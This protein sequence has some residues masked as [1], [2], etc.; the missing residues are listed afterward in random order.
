MRTVKVPIRPMTAENFLPYGHL[1]CADE[2]PTDRRVMSLMP[3]QCDGE[4]TVST[5]WQPAAN[6]G[7]SQLERHY[8]VT[9]TFFQLS[10][11][12]AIV[13]V[14]PPSPADDP[15]AIPAP[16]SVVGFLINADQG[17]SFHIGVWHSLDRM[18]LNPPGATFIIL[19]VEPNPTQIVDYA[20]GETTMH[21]NLY[22]EPPPAVSQLPAPHSPITFEL[23]L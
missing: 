1:A 14:A 16:E 3:F 19:N 6:T 18:V 21:P 8:G 23:D 20:T 22:G 12:P 5:I 2:R 7:F 11:S 17:Y 4:T 15:E 9:Q 10:G 13:C